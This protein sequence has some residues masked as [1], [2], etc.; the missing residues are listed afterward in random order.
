MEQLDSIFSKRFGGAVNI[1]GISYQIRY[2]ILRAFELYDKKIE[3]LTLEGIEDL[4][5][6]GFFYDDDTFIQVKTSASSWKWHQIKK[7]LV[8][9]I[10]IYKVN[11]NAKFVLV[12]NN[13]YKGDIEQLS[14]YT[15]LDD[16]DKNEIEKKFIKLRQKDVQ[17][18]EE[19]LLNLLKNL[20]FI[21]LTDEELMIARSVCHVLGFDTS[22][23]EI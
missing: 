12:L 22:I 10:E 2:S 14:K 13:S 11:P 20:T 23:K 3:S 16:K 8:N 17:E 15:T 7:P 19:L 21:C 9:F 5:L 4:D 18:S 1:R 6:K